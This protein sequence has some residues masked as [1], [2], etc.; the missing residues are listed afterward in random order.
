MINHI[1]YHHHHLDQHEVEAVRDVEL[2]DDHVEG[3][4]EDEDG[5]ECEDE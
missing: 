4:A 2:G 1:F 3:V 5:G